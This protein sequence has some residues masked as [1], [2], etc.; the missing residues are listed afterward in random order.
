MRE[1]HDVIVAIEKEI[2]IGIQ[3]SSLNYYIAVSHK[4]WDL[5]N[6]WIWL[7]EI[8]S[9]VDFPIWTGI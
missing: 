7:A 4:E 3:V 6:S 9:N 1:V 2:F 8:E 5:P